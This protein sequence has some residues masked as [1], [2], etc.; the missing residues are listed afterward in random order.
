MKTFLNKSLVVIA[1]G[2]VLAGGVGCNK[3]KDFEDTNLNPNGTPIPVTAGLLTRA[4][5]ELGGSEGGVAIALYTR[6]GY[7]AQYFSETQYPGSSLYA[8][9]QLN[10]NTYYSGFLYDLQNIINLNTDDAT[11]ASVES[12]GSNANQIAVAR[13]LK[14]YA[15]WTITDRWGDVPYFEALQGIAT[16]KLDKQEEIYPD[17]L[18]EL[19]EAVA[20]FDGGLAMKGD[21]IYG[22]EI[23]NWKRFANSLRMLIALR[24]SKVYPA[25]GGL[26]ATEFSAALNDPAGSI[27][28]NDQNAAI[29]YPGGAYQ[30]PLYTSYSVSGRIDDAISSTMTDVLSS[31]SDPRINEFGSETTGFPYGIDR[32][33]AVNVAPGWGLIMG[34]MDLPE[35]QDIVLVNAATVLFARAEAAERGWTGESAVALYNDGV[36]TSLEQ[37]GYTDAAVVNAYLAQSGVVFGATDHL[38]KIATQRWIAMYPDGMQAWSEWRRTGFPVL[39]P[40]EDATND[41][42]Q[43][44][45]RFVYGTGEYSTNKA[46][47]DEAVA[48]IPGGD[49]D[50]DARMWW[51]K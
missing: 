44:P 16:P 13:I 49:D 5:A 3:I 15:F 21:I 8:V 40:A 17:L 1:T 9:P 19:K 20:G 43:I 41:G 28:E 35:D 51:D 27:T 50:Q 11:K 38:R 26:A 45:R 24:M 39:T 37:W 30:H 48:R 12:S 46:A 18:K 32:D 23:A 47:V 42:G 6:P 10:Y 14:A 33:K 2:L 7:Y 31:L 4:I 29:D 34:G 25:A 22:G 36:E